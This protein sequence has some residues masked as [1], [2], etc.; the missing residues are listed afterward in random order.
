MFSDKKKVKSTTTSPSTA[1]NRIVK[2]TKIIGKV[3]SDGGFRI[4]GEIEGDVKTEG[5]VVIGITGK[6][7]GTLT[8]DNADIEGEFN[9]KLIV[10]EILSLRS[11]AQID[12]EVFIGKLAVEPGASFNATCKMGAGMKNLKVNSLEEKTA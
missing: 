6:I 4:D 11:T 5:K 12:G 8:C 10:K 1:Q 7:K 9:G 2:G 3:V